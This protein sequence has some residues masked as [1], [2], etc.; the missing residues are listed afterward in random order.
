MTISLQEGTGGGARGK[1]GD[2]SF[3]DPLG[4]K[5][6][7]PKKDKKTAEELAL[8]RNQ[9]S[10][11]DKEIETNEE[12]FKLLARG[13]LGRQSLLSGGPRNVQESAGG[14][15]STSSRSAGSLFNNI[16]AASSPARTGSPIRTGRR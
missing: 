5:K 12:R 14:A 3:A 8:E 9:R 1:L 2:R 11:L 13:K 10:L 15:R 16:R 4:L 6:S 7:K